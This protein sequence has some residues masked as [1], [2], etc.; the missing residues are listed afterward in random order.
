MGLLSFLGKTL[1]NTHKYSNGEHHLPKPKTKFGKTIYVVLSIIALGI[2]A[3]IL[4]AEIDRKTAYLDHSRK[5]QGTIVESPRR[6]LINIV[7]TC[8]LRNRV[9]ST[10]G[11][12]STFPEQ[13]IIQFKTHT[14]QDQISKTPYCSYRHT[15]LLPGQ[16]VTL[17]Y[18]PENPSDIIRGNKDQVELKLSSNIF[19]L[20]IMFLMV[21]LI[22]FHAL[23][24]WI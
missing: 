11:I 12:S 23:Y 16:Q 14:G 4:L 9:G 1:E 17:H 10:H 2:N 5:A 21:G 8:L 18:L 20:C 7:E 3:N 13:L 19:K 15:K 22:F 6:V 24:R